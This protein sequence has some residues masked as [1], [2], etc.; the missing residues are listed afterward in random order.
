MKIKK[1]G[2]KLIA[3]RDENDVNSIGGVGITSKI[4]VGDSLGSINLKTGKFVGNA[5]CLLKLKKKQRKYIEKNED[6]FQELVDE[7]IEQ[8][9][10]D[11][12]F[13]DTT[14]LNEILNG[15]SKERLIQSLPEEKW[16]EYM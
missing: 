5:I 4:K 13:L 10:Y 15:V 9:L 2:N 3:Y 6:K 1:K 8:I 11:A 16:K 14:V 7:V 12:D